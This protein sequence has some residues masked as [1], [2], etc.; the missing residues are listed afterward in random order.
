MRAGR[1]EPPGR[2]AEYMSVHTFFTG[3]RGVMAPFAGFYLVNA[4]SLPVLGSIAAGMIFLIL[5]M[6]YI[7]VMDF[8]N[9]AV[10]P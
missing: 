1:G 2:V 5:L 6:I 7:N 9:P 10:I 8:V 3:V 4:L